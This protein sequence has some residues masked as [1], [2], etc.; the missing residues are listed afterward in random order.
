MSEPRYSVQEYVAIE[1]P[2]A[3]EL[4]AFRRAGAEAVGLSFFMGPRAGRPDL[5]TMARTLQGSG[6]A[7]SACWPEIASILPVPG[8][9]GPQDPAARTRTMVD[10]VRSAAILEPLF[11]GCVTGPA[12]ALPI[13]EARAAVVAGL[14]EVAREAG[15]AGIQVVVEP[16]HPS[17]AGMFSIVSSLLE[18]AE[19]IDEVGE[20]SLGI[21][22]DMWHSCWEP[23]LAASIQQCQD[24]IRHV[25]L[26]DWREP[27]RSWCDR[28]LPGEGIADVCGMLGALDAVGYEGLYELEVLSDDGTYEVD[29]PDSLWHLDPEALVRRGRDRFMDAWR[30]RVVPETPRA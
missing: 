7:V 13:A 1:V 12:G 10:L 2:F 18:T 26:S 28:A 27:T 16:I 30:D 17:N 22:F 4:E 14:R 11:I 25:H 23:D 6:L 21:V 3:A 24:K 8:F 5:E 19:L 20:S 15:A 9:P 29:Y